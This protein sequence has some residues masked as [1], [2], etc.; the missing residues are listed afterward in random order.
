MT[1]ARMQLLLF[2]VFFP[3]YNLLAQLPQHPFTVFGPLKAVKH[4]G[5][6]SVKTSISLGFCYSRHLANSGDP[7]VTRP[8]KHTDPV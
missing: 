1:D 5:V 7:C 8:R 4:S 6:L 2:P 3:L